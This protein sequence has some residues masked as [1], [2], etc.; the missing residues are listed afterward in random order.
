[1]KYLGSSILFLF[2]YFKQSQ[3]I[4]FEQVV[5]LKTATDKI[6]SKFLFLTILKATTKV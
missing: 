5:I 3:P 1:M 6:I 2:S 4:V